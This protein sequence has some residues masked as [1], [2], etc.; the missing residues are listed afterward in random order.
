MESETLRDKGDQEV[1]ISNLQFDAL[2]GKLQ[3]A[4][5]R[6]CELEQRLQNYESKYRT[7]FNEDQVMHITKGTHQGSEWSD[8]SV[9]RGLKLYLAC[10]V[11]GYEEIRNQKLPYPSI[12]TLQ[13]RI[14]NIQFDTGVLQ[15]IF[16]LLDLRVVKARSDVFLIG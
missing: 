13:H 6:I 3:A 16:A 4:Y 10:G 12:R 9:N 2:K 11:K 5:K 15:D 8:D 1:F 14:R 7:V